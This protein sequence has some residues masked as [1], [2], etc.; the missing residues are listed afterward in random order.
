MYPKAHVFLSET[1]K[2][3]T[4]VIV[5]VKMNGCSLITHISYNSLIPHIKYEF[6]WTDYKVLYLANCAIIPALVGDISRRH[7][8][9]QWNAFRLPWLYVKL[10]DCTS[11]AIRF[12]SG[13]NSENTET[14]MNDLISF[15]FKRL[16]FFPPLG[17][18]ASA[19]PP[20]VL[21]SPSMGLSGASSPC[22]LFN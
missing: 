22:A 10:S 8:D 16:S 12:L 6:H 9:G 17:P 21:L 19:C 7:K 20:G 3:W 4:C 2:Q 1:N 5:P 11:V 18:L 13:G 15:Y 14:R